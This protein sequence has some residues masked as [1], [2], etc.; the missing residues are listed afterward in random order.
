MIKFGPIFKFKREQNG[1]GPSYNQGLVAYY[2]SQG[3]VYFLCFKNH[4]G[5][6]SG[7]HDFAPDAQA[8]AERLTK[9]SLKVEA[10]FLPGVYQAVS[11]KASN[12]TEKHQAYKFTLVRILHYEALGD[13]SPQVA[14]LT[15][16]QA[17][18][19]LKSPA[20]INILTMA[21]KMI[22]RAQI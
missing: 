4:R 16:E 9:F 17:S 14:W 1:A 22:R 18:Q 5:L 11:D 8:L 20:E 13:L 2:L 19:S 6:L 21:Y 10:K 15:Q 12:Q 7:Y 3:I